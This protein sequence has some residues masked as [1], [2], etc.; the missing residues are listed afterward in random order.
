MIRR[1]PRSTRTDTLFPYTTLYRSNRSGGFVKVTNRRSR[2]NRTANWHQNDSTSPLHVTPP[3]VSFR[4]PTLSPKRNR[5]G[6]PGDFRSHFGNARGQF[7]AGRDF[8]QGSPVLHVPTVSP[9]TGTEP[10]PLWS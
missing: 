10:P 2:A 7:A 6:R 9:Q 1:P 5:G 4:F 3:P 8:A